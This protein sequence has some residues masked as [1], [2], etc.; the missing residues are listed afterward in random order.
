MNTL[1]KICAFD[2]MSI[3]LQ[4]DNSHH[5]M[6]HSAPYTTRWAW[7]L[8]AGRC[9][10]GGSPSSVVAGCGGVSRGELPNGA[11]FSLS[12]KTHLLGVYPCS[13]R[14]FPSACSLQPRRDLRPGAAVS[15]LMGTLRVPSRARASRPAASPL[16][17]RCPRPLLSAGFAPRTQRGLGGRFCR[18]VPRSAGPVR[19]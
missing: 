7:P 8:R 11:L 1:F 18:P 17:A 12:T 3:I 4:F 10:A 6:P 19:F 9:V 2:P 16:A 13:V 15:F 14:F 5:H